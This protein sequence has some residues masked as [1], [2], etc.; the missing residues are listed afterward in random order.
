ML[1]DQEGIQL[2]AFHGKVNEE[3]NGREGGT[4]SKDVLKAKNGRWTFY[5]AT[6]ELKIGDTL[7]YW[8]YVDY[9]DG[10]NKLGY[11]NDDQVFVVNELLDKRTALNTSSRPPTITNKTPDVEILPNGCKAS[12]TIS[13]NQKMCEGQE[14]FSEDF[15]KL[16]PEFWNTEVK[17]AGKPV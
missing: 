6:A 13:K 12:R 11:A 14:I 7:Y 2:F 1:A 4:F 17:F 16:R 5:D 10:K 8:T 15:E 9:F 3:M